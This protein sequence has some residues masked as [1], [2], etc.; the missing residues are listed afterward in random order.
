MAASSTHNLRYS[1]DDGVAQCS[2]SVPQTKTTS[3]DLEIIPIQE[4]PYMCH[5]ASDASPQRGFR[6][7]AVIAG[8]AIAN[9][10]A[11]L[12]HSVV[13]TAGPTITSDLDMEESFIWITNSFFVCR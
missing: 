9:F 11:S 8:L 6:F 10:L 13:V 4:A 12:E 5:Q 1:D 7:W 2:D 3:V